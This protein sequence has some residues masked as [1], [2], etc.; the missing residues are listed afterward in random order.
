MSI[1][2]DI[3]FVDSRPIILILVFIDELLEI[4]LIIGDVLELSKRVIF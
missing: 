1:L 2:S 3:G 4:L